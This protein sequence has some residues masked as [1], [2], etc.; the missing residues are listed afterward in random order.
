MR[1]PWGTTLCLVLIMA[2]HGILGCKVEQPIVRKDAASP[3]QEAGGPELGP[4]L[5]LYNPP[6]LAIADGRP[7]APDGHQL[8]PDIGAGADADAG[9]VKLS[10]TD[11]TFPHFFNANLLP[12][13]LSHLFGSSVIKPSRP[14]V[15]V[16]VMNAGAAGVYGALVGAKLSSYSTVSPKKLYLPPGKT[17]VVELTPTLDL[18]KLFTVT[19]DVYDT[20]VAT[21][22]HNGKVV[23]T[24]SRQVLVANRNA[25]DTAKLKP[26]GAAMVTPKDKKGTVA[27][28]SIQAGAKMPGKTWAGYQKMYAKPWSKA[29]AVSFHEDDA[30]YLLQGHQICVSVTGVTTADS[31]KEIDLLVMDDANYLLFN[32]GKAATYLTSIKGAKAG[33]S[34]CFKAAKSDWHHMVYLNLSTNTASRTVT[35]QRDASH[36]DIVY[37]HGEA[38]FDV[39]KTNGVTLTNAPKKGTFW[40][41]VKDLR[42]ASDTIKAKGGTCLDG[43]LLFASVFEAAGLRPVVILVPDHA[44]VGIRIWSN[45]DVV[46]PIE[47]TLVGTGTFK[48]AYNSGAQQ[49]NTYFYQ[50]K[51]DLV[52]VEL[53]RNNGVTPAPF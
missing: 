50:G 8:V 13:S 19:S 14:F 40:K 1:Y 34:L 10:I 30:T 16:S 6:D 15:Q 44:L 21:V 52:D 12:T 17:T 37:Y 5:D 39:L 32:T 36:F 7:D 47:T 31:T 46:I 41:S 20:V 49:Y 51:L 35:R 53:A 38:L 27:T 2:G 11:I 9:Q 43:A 33:S 4:L 45:E 28:L 29:I 23:A 22:T 42:Y 26:W 24:D 48:A 18:T 25:F 3:G